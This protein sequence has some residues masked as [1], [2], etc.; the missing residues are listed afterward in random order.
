MQCGARNVTIVL[1][2]AIAMEALSRILLRLWGGSSLGSRWLVDA[3][4]G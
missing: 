3:V 2:G 1:K 4:W